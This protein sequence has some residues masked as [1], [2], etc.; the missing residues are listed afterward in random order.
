MKRMIA[1]VMTLALMVICLPS[2]L[3]ATQY[4]DGYMVA[5][6]GGV[7][8]EFAQVRESL[9]QPR[10]W[11]KFETYDESGDVLYYIRI[12]FD[13]G[14]EIG[15]FTSDDYE[16]DRHGVTIQLGDYTDRYEMYEASFHEL[17]EVDPFDN[18]INSYMRPI[19]NEQRQNVGY[20]EMYVEEEL[21]NGCYYYGSFAAAAES[22][23][24]YYYEIYA[25]F[26]MQVA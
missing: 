4:M 12:G 10:K 2:A 5:E 14:I 25:E 11:M 1:I 20:I 19:Y 22:D 26:I 9:N 7:E 8:Y 17:T 24:G 6:I 23:N 21:E 13:D 18:S 16:Y 15:E 3:A